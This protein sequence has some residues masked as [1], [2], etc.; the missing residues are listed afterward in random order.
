MPHFLAII[1]FIGIT[2]YVCLR[3]FD[4]M[5]QGEVSY[6]SNYEFETH[7]YKRSTN[8]YMFWQTVVMFGLGAIASFVIVVLLVMGKI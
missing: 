6:R 5:R 3:I 2:I 4:A 1:I 7:Y 8:P